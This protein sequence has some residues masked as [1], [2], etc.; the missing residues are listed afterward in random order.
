MALPEALVG[1]QAPGFLLPQGLVP[2]CLQHYCTT[3]LEPMPR[4][5]A[6]DLLLPEGLVPPYL[7]QLPWLLEAHA[8]T[9]IEPRS[10]TALWAPD[11]SSSPVLLPHWNP[12]LATQC[13][14]PA[15]THPSEPQAPGFAIFWHQEASLLTE[16]RGPALPTVPDSK[17]TLAPPPKSKN[18]RFPTEG[19]KAITCHCRQHHK[20]CPPKY[21]EAQHFMLH[22]PA[23]ESH[24]SC[25]RVGMPAPPLSGNLLLCWC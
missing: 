16:H 10:S 7:Q 20:P 14:E 19:R 8:P 4:M 2:P 24:L 22:L 17:R 21:T 18:A 13:Q 9:Q 11:D 25:P 23:E 12:Q 3:L 15:T 6:P 1:N 5:Q